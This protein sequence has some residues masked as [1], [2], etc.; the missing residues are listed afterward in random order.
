MLTSQMVELASFPTPM[1][2]IGIVS[3]IVHSLNKYVLSAFY[4]EI[5]A[6]GIKDI[7]VDKTKIATL[8][9]LAF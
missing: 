6:L 7:A 5:F 3:N 9:E 8:L 4:C 1:P 2:R